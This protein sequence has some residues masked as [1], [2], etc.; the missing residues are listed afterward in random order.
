[1]RVVQIDLDSPEPGSTMS[2]L[3]RGS[4]PAARAVD[5]TKSYGTGDAVVRGLD[6]VD[7]EFERGR[8][9]AVIGASGSGVDAD[10]LHGGAG[11]T[12]VGVRSR[13]GR[14]DRA[15]QRRAL[16]RHAPGP[17]G[18]VFQSF[19]LV[20]T[21]SQPRTSRFRST[22]PGT[23]SIRRGLTISSRRSA[24]PIGCRTVPV[25]CPVASSSVSACARALIR[26][27]E[28]NF[29]DEPTGNLDSTS[30]AELLAF[31][32]DAA[33]EPGSRS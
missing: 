2:K 31:L 7:V 12:N 3:D 6:G 22:S 20:P 21:L 23:R 15:A 27:P 33:S 29:A 14:G 10:A 11:R 13:R 18:F 4:E 26:R 5:L 16:D 9:T 17:V 19:N 28:L 25:G 1:M 8:F 24:S 32:R 30:S